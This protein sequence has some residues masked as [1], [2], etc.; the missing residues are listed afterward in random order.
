MCNL[1]RK[2]LDADGR[3]DKLSTVSSW[4]I[5]IRLIPPQSL[6]HFKDAYEKRIDQLIARR[7]ARGRTM[8]T[9]CLFVSDEITYAAATA[10][11]G[12][13]RKKR[14]HTTR[15]RNATTINSGIKW[16]M[17]MIAKSTITKTSAMSA[18]S[19]SVPIRY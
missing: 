10:R 4:L 3:R 6:N 19:V 14:S 8:N 7:K 15:R 5:L 18:R 2:S 16:M 17:M 11:G 9:F 12:R 13:R 1:L